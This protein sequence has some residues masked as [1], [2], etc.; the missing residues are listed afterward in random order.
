MFRKLDKFY[1][2][3]PNNKDP[4]E[5]ENI[6]SKQM[7]ALMKQNFM[8]G[9]IYFLTNLKKKK[10]ITIY[11]M[12]KTVKQ[13]LLL[14]NIP[15]VNAGS[16]DYFI[17]QRKKYLSLGDTFVHY[18][19]GLLLANGGYERPQY[20]NPR[21]HIYMEDPSKICASGYGGEFRCIYIKDADK[22]YKNLMKKMEWFFTKWRIDEK[23]K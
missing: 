22:E 14:I 6:L 19:T 4:Y 8:Y 7:I 2:D 3:L 9:V 17:T 11:D 23:K 21:G 13:Q 18:P 1:Q 5:I 20:K 10:D 16:W 15:K 12:D